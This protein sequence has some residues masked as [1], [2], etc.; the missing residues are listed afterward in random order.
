[1]RVEKTN[2]LQIALRIG[3][4]PRLPNPINN[5][6]LRF[7]LRQVQ[8]LR[9]IRLVGFIINPTIRLANRVPG[10]MQKVILELAKKLPPPSSSKSVYS[11]AAPNSNSKESSSKNEVAR[12]WY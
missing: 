4:H 9:R 12:S 6:L 5:P 8:P 10:I 1:M 7:L 2:P 3:T 11:R